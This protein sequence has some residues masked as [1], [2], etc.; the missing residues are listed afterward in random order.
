MIRT[1]AR[2]AALAAVVAVALLTNRAQATPV[3]TP[4]PLPNGAFGTT[5]SAT[6]NAALTSAS[7]NYRTWTNIPFIGFVSTNT[8][9]S[10]SS[11]SP[12]ITMPNVNIA[13][14]PASATSNITYDNHAPPSNLSLNSLNA[15]LNGAGAANQN[16]P[17][18]I[19]AGAINVSSSLGTFPL[20]LTVNGQI[21]DARFDSSG[22]PADASSGL[23]SIPG[24]LSLTI[25]GTVNG[26]ISILG[27]PISLGTIYTLPSTT[28]P[29]VTSLPGAMVLTDLSGGAG[30]YPANMKVD[31]LAGGIPSV[32]FSTSLP[33][34][35]VLAT[36]PGGHTAGLT[37]L[38]VGAG[39]A[40]NVTFT[41]GNPQYDLNGT[42]P[43]AVVPE[44]GS[45]AIAGLGFL[46]MAGLCWRKKQA[47]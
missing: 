24:T 21:T 31:L 45:L 25:Q 12:S 23:Y 22:T 3:T 18:T 43:L 27:I 8:G 4:A 15:D 28:L 16:Y 38:I 2:F 37:S 7:G 46:A 10:A 9:L 32:N 13:N 6:G 20:T 35:G 41:L 17:F 14:A 34:S 39:S 30:P 19:S 5:L 47:A 36:D 33:F 40:L 42:L 11:Q 26:S 44:P 1:K 29:I